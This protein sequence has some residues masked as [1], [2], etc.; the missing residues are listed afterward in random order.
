M[1]KNKYITYI[2]IYIYIHNGQQIDR[3]SKN[4]IKIF[5]DFWF[6]TDIETNSK[7]VDFLN[8]TFNLNNGIHELY[9]K[10]NDTVI[11]KQELQPP[12]TNN[13]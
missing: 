9:K 1:Y 3:A 4:I 10:P 7:V 2:Y 12:T 11:Y 6:D 8:I 13:Q 5:I